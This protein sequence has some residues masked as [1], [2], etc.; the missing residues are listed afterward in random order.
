MGL[1]NLSAGK[2]PSSNPHMFRF[3][4]RDVLV[5]TAAVAWYVASQTILHSDGG[6]IV[7]N[8]VELTVLT[9]SYFGL[10]A[11]LIWHSRFGSSPNHP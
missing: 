11:G 2:S 1:A 6:A 5:L 9:V 8:P 7:A 3:T 4:I 10:V